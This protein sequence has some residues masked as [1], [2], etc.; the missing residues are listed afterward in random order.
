MRWDMHTHNMIYLWNLKTFLGGGGV[1]GGAL[2][3]SG[4]QAYYYT[5]SS[6]EPHS[7]LPAYANIL[8]WSQLIYAHSIMTLHL[9]VY[10]LHH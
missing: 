1:G 8:T 9:H 6:C 5:K 7:V 4:M 3:V 10:K 2:V